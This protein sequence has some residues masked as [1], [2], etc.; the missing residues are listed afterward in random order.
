M[1]PIPPPPPHCRQLFMATIVLLPLL[2]L[3]WVFGLLS[4]NRSTTFFA[5]IF[6]FLNSFQVSILPPTTTTTNKQRSSNL[7]IRLHSIRLLPIRNYT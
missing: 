7:T 1:N 6:T 3:T 4:V 2:G 5:W